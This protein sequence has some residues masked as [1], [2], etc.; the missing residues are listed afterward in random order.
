MRHTPR[1]TLRRKTPLKR[2]S[3]KKSMPRSK[4]AKTAQESVS[5]LKKRLDAIFSRFIRV[6]DGGRCFTCGV[7]K[8]IGNMQAGHYISRSHNA[9]RFDERNVNCQCVGCNIFKRGNTDEYAIRLID[10]CGPDILHEL[11]ALKKQIRQFT[12][13]ELASLI[14][15][16][17]SK[18]R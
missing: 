9:T 6:R 14:L 15:F 11:N 2:T 17:Q 3:V 10:K 7:V 8:S 18:L 1:H 5:Q 16:Y 12:R 4:H 13:E